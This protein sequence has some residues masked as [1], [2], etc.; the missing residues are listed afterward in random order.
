MKPLSRRRCPKCSSTNVV[1][2][3]SLQSYASGQIFNRF[4]CRKCGYAG[5]F[6]VEE[7]KNPPKKK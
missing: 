6:F 3:L 2:D 7:V 5:V 1:A 4:K